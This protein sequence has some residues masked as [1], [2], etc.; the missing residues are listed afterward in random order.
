M[1]ISDL[2]NIEEILT[3]LETAL[4]IDGMDYSE[5]DATVILNNVRTRIA[6]QYQ[7]DLRNTKMDD[8]T[9]YVDKFR[10]AAVLFMENVARVHAQLCGYLQVARYN[11]DIIISP[12]NIGYMGYN[13]DSFMTVLRYC[14]NKQTIPSAAEPIESLKQKLGTVTICREKRVILLMIV[15][16][17][18]G[19]YEVMA[20][21]AEIMYTGGKAKWPTN[22]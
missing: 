10:S 7:V 14:M 3:S 19:F 5:R 2:Y 12:R 4:Q 9:L 20:S 21:L 11:T 8:P 22:K 18:L 16:Y 6:R 17:E 15:S 13:D 1:V